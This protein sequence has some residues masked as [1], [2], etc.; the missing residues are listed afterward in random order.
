MENPIKKLLT[1]NYPEKYE[2][3]NELTENYK[4]RTHKANNKDN[5]SKVYF[6]LRF[7]FKSGGEFIIS[8]QV[9]ED[10]KVSKAI[11]NFRTLS[12]MEDDFKFIFNDKELNPDLTIK[13]SGINKDSIIFVFRK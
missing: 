9:T 8:I 1:N 3:I 5:S 12:V 13:E 10:M 7:L 4:E 2:P 6:S 11:T